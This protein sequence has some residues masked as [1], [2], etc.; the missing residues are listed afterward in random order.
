MTEYINLAEYLFTRLHQ[1]G[2]KALHGVPGDYNLAA[3]DFVV[4]SGL[5]WVGSCNE[6][7]AGYAADGYARAKGI[8]ALVTTFGVGELSAINAIAGAY[9]EH[10]PVVHIVGTP[11]REIQ[12]SRILV[13][14][15]LGDGNFDAFASMYARV[16]VAQ[17]NLWDPETAP[18]MIDTTLRECF[19]QSRPVYIQLPT[20]MV[21]AKVSK[22]LLDTPIDISPA[23]N[24]SKR[25]EAIAERILDRI[26]SA[27][28]PFIIVDGA[29]RKGFT[30]EVNEFVR[31]SG[32]PTATTSFGKG[33]LDENIPNFHGVYAGESGKLNYAE[34]FRSCDLVIRFGPEDTDINSIT[35]TAI[36][37]KE[38]RIDFD[39]RT[40]R[41]PGIGMFGTEVIETRDLLRNILGRLDT[42]KLHKYDP[43]PQLGS[44][45]QLV[46]GLSPVQDD[47]IIDQRTFFQRLSGFFKPG[48][49]ILTE[50]GTSQIGGSDFALPSNTA[51]ITSPSWSSIGFA[52][53]AAQG[54]AF[55]QKEKNPTAPDRTILFQGDGSFQL[56]AQELS[57]V[58]RHKLNLTFFFI[59]NDGYT[60]ERALHG[61]KA[62]YNDVASW[63]YLEALSFFGAPTEGEYEVQAFTARNWGE[64]NKVLADESFANGRGLKMVEIFMDKEDY[65]DGLRYAA[66]A[67]EK[68]LQTRAP[69]A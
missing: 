14:H 27:K 15:N 55:A 13:H 53:P 49:I 45:K 33:I 29:V 51:M 5:D 12:N 19:K 64:M 6:L 65:P 54:V 69:G 32:F 48:D 66:E 56:T 18:K 11:N 42:A 26:Y 44:S 23:K 25:E 34:F 4:P 62:H 3:L 46:E 24:D 10:S 58:I 21:F 20:D 67:R 7:N 9:A 38:S 61:L 2:V 31:T 59:N 43:Y 41:M 50:T 22:S 8:G 60:I 35:W 63:R 30:A 40:V 1:I 16:T 52:L 57:T 36:P 28:Q 39:L 17:A 37:P 68:K 47:A